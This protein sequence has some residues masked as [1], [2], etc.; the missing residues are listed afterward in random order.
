M[1]I[2]TN[3]N[4]DIVYSDEILNE[5]EHQ[6]KFISLPNSI[7][8][9]FE[10]SDIFDTWTKYYLEKSIISNTEMEYIDIDD[11]EYELSQSGL[12]DVRV[13]Y[14]QFVNTILDLYYHFFSINFENRNDVDF[15]QLY[16]LY[17]IFVLHF[18][19]YT[20]LFIIHCYR[21]EKIIDEATSDLEISNESLNSSMKDI[22]TGYES[23]NELLALVSDD[24]PMSKNEK[25]LHDF[26]N[27]KISELDVNSFLDAVDDEE[28]GNINIHIVKDMID[29]FKISFENETFIQTMI[30]H[31]INNIY[32]R[33]TIFK[34]IKERLTA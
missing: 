28:P 27:D 9:N 15:L 3:N 21:I 1:N 25:I 10:F 19:Y 17:D 12:D 11:V 32:T 26:I 13:Y 29:F 4:Q 18:T 7:F 8:E 5:L 20:A 2:I 24:D 23:S 14:D 16:A 22:L 34:I 31:C 33:D 6:I 30:L